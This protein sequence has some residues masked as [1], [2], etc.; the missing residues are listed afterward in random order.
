MVGVEGTVPKDY[1][2]PCP[3]AHALDIVGDRWTLLVV[4]DLMSLGPR[5]Y[6]ELQASLAGIAPNVLSD[7][8]KLLEE[9]G[10]V[11][12]EFYEQHPPR[13]RYKLTRKGGDLRTVIHALVDWGNRYEYD[14]LAI[15]HEPC[16]HEVHV[17]QVCEHCKTAVAPR[18][19]TRKFKTE[20]AARAASGER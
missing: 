11:E 16:G 17:E 9:H 7:R 1:G 2:L 10:I 4:R 3:V 14:G 5:K 20:E 18:E 6:V 8:L 12:R 15:V 13:A 19:M